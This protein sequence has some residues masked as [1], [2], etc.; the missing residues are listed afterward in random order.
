MPDMPLTIFRE[1]DSGLCEVDLLSRYFSKIVQNENN[2]ITVFGVGPGKN[3][4]VV[5]KEQIGQLR[6]ISTN[7]YW[8]P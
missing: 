4:E 3:N 8:V 6:T 1:Y 2:D 5:S 7:L